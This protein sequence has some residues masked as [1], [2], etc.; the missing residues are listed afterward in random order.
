MGSG[1]VEVDDDFDEEEDHVEPYDYDDY[2]RDQKEAAWEAQWEYDNEVSI[3]QD[4][5]SFHRLEKI[6]D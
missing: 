5:Y 3:K 1:E 2:K 4:K 6:L